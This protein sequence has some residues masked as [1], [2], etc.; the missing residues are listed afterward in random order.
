M[1]GAEA[2]CQSSPEAPNHARSRGRTYG[3]RRV[4]RV[5]AQAFG[6]LD[7]RRVKRCETPSISHASFG[8]RS[9]TS[10]DGHS[11]QDVAPVAADEDVTG[12]GTTVLVCK[13]PY[14]AFVP[15]LNASRVQN[16]DPELN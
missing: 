7:V 14:S 16:D 4:A 13:I 15:G 3:V 6:I 10:K 12:T 2:R 8:V 5:E 9:K 1:K 11:L